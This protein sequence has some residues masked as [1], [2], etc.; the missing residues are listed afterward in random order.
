[1]KKPLSPSVLE[2]EIR[3]GLALPPEKCRSWLEDLS[4]EAGF[5]GFCWLWGPQLAD[6]RDDVAICRMLLPWK[7]GS[8]VNFVSKGQS[9]KANEELRR[10][11]QLQP[12]GSARLQVDL[13]KF[14]FWFAL[15]EDTA[16][17]VYDRLPS[18]CG[19]FLLR[20]LP[21]QARLFWDRLF[22]RVL[23]RDSRAAPTIAS[24]TASQPGGQ[25]RFAG[26]AGLS[27]DDSSG[28][29]QSAVA[30]GRALSAQA[31]LR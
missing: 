1:M 16:L 11:L 6:E 25:P 10:R 9:Q 12:A 28:P 2:R 14:D 17:L 29:G 22:S 21:G 15:N 23:E 31:T 18:G 3:H 13:A 19:P 27:L 30:D 26:E 5:S 4:G 24:R 8:A 20:H 7:L